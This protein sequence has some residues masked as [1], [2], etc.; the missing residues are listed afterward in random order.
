MTV[1]PAPTWTAQIYC[2]LRP[3]YTPSLHSPRVPLRVCQEYCDRVNLCV[4]VTP[5]TFLYTGGSEP[6]VIV[7]L[8]NYPRFPAEPAALKA[9]DLELAGL[10]KQRLGQLRVTVVM[11]DETV[12][13]GGLSDD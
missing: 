10:L 7:G 13:L 3:G 2:G 8:I 12:T 4:T 1:T 6:G 9:R 11:P 5:T